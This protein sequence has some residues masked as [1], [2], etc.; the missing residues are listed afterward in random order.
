MPLDGFGIQATERRDAE[1]LGW[2]E[3]LGDMEFDLVHVRP[4]LRAVGDTLAPPHDDD[5]GGVG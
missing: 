3:W 1:L 2:Q 4:A 5:A